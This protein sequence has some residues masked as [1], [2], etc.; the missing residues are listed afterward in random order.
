MNL[1]N[2]NMPIPERIAHKTKFG[3]VDNTRGENTMEP[4]IELVDHYHWMR[5][6]DR[7]NKKVIEHLTLE[8]SYT[9]FV[10]KEI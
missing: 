9:D 6:D 4:P 1:N 3:N 5:D 8:N 7:K 10:M 2:Q